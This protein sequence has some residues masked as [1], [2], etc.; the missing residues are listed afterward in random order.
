MSSSKRKE[1]KEEMSKSA[2]AQK[3]LEL[4]GAVTSKLAATLKRFKQNYCSFS[5]FLFIMKQMCIHTNMYFG[6]LLID[7]SSQLQIIFLTE[8]TT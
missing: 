7:D 6:N 1:A 2:P 4:L 5:F 8:R 3:I